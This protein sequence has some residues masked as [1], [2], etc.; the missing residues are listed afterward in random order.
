MRCLWIHL[1]CAFCAFSQAVEHPIPQPNSY[2][3][4]FAGPALALECV[5]VLKLAAVGFPKYYATKS[6]AERRDCLGQLLQSLK[7]EPDFTADD[8]F[9]TILRDPNHNLV[10]AD[11]ALSLRMLRRIGVNMEVA[12]AIDS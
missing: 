1:L 9:N 3:Y 4:D 6:P 2:G 5:G 8:F 12:K 10:P 11:P 7:T